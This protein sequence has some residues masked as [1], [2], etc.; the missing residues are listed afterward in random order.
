MAAFAIW[1]LFLVV[2]VVV[3]MPLMILLLFFPKTRPAAV[4][5]LAGVGLIV[6]LLLFL[7]VPLTSELSSNNPPIV[8]MIPK[9]DA[10]PLDQSD[11]AVA[12]KPDWVDAEPGTVGDA[13]RM[14]VAVGPYTTRAECD[15]HL[16]GALQ[17]A[18]DRYAAVCFAD[19]QPG[20]RIVLPDDFLSRL[21]KEYWEETRE[22]SVGPMTTLHVL[23][24]FDRKAKDRVQDARR[25]SIVGDRIW[26]AGLGF[27]AWIVF[28]GVLYAVLQLMGR[29]TPFS[30]P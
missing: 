20:R 19:E 30:S 7:V 12:S 17:D 1:A 24:E 2:L 6:V 21:V 4:S 5:I 14:S 11:T 3:G 13:Y 23:L 22:Y 25:R 15:A 27:F 18:I 26:W 16:P 29:K 28:L 10:A 8:E 9:V